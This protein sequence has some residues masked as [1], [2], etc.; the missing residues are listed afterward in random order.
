MGVN[1]TPIIV[2][3]VLSLDDLRGK[4]FAVDSQI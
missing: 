1:L 3:T 4:S 2:K